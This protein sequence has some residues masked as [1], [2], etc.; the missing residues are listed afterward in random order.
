MKSIRTLHLIH[1]FEQLSESLPNLD[2]TTRQLR[3]WVRSDVGPRGNHEAQR[4]SVMTTR[5]I[6]QL[7][8]CCTGESA[9]AFEFV[10]ARSTR[11]E[12]ADQAMTVEATCPGSNSARYDSGD[13]NHPHSVSDGRTA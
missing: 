8:K 11:V 6:Q 12:G 3:P 9:A 13:N 1:V 2:L 4:G 5:S 10:R 7:V